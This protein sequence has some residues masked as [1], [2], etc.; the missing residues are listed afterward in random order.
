LAGHQDKNRENSLSVI[1]ELFNQIC[2]PILRERLTSELI[3]SDGI[4]DRGMFCSEP[5][6]PAA[7]LIG[8]E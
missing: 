7:L 2:D 8:L 5:E 4:Q 1:Q 3:L 6:K